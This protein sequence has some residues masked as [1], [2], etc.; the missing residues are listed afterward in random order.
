M[1][2]GFVDKSGAWYSYGK[3]RIGQGK[4]NAK[5]YLR[6]NPEMAAE[7][8]ALLREKLLPNLNKSAADSSEEEAETA[9]A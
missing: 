3:D 6:E 7:L 2:H 9:E 5:A 4:E 1:K 8:D